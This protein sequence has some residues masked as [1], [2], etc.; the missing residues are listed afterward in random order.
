MASFPRLLFDVLSETLKS[1]SRAAQFLPTGLLVWLGVGRIYAS[2]HGWGVVGLVWARG[3]LG[4]G[5]GRWYRCWLSDVWH[6]GCWLC[7]GAGL[8]DGWVVACECKGIWVGG[9]RCWSLSS[10][11]VFRVGRGFVRRGLSA[12]LGFSF[13]ASIARSSARFRSLDRSPSFVWPWWLLCG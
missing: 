2:S 3:G 13:V 5:S 11:S 9:A 10:S 7:F 4:V 12:P 8:V 1:G 6:E